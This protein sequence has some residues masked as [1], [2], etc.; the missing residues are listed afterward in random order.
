MAFHAPAVL[1]VAAP[2]DIPTQEL[3]FQST[4]AL[5]ALFRRACCNHPAVPNPAQPNFLQ[6]I[7]A[8]L[9]ANQRTQ[10]FKGWIN[11]ETQTGN[12]YYGEIHDNLVTAIPDQAHRDT[13]LA[14][15]NGVR[16]VVIGIENH[17]HTHF[18]RWSFDLQVRRATTAQGIQGVNEPYHYDHW[19]GWTQFGAGVN[20]P[21]YVI[22]IYWQNYF[23]V[24]RTLQVGHLGQLGG[25][26]MGDVQ[27]LGPG[28]WPFKVAI[29][30]QLHF[31]HRPGVPNPQYGAQTMAANPGENWRV[32]L[33]IHADTHGIPRRLHGGTISTRATRSKSRSK[34]MN[35][36][37]QSSKR[38][39]STRSASKPSPSKKST[40]S[41][42]LSVIIYTEVLKLEVVENKKV[43]RFKEED[44][45]YLTKEN[46]DD[47]KV[48]KFY[49]KNKHWLV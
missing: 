39:E 4:P 34:T 22:C 6:F 17:L 28:D 7:D 30:D 11:N 8:M 14:F 18:N 21:R 15:C 26:H 49:P 43:Y 37:K 13:C 3:T 27:Y 35:S 10:P 29:V 48:K 41:K 20:N 31:H 12:A 32:M 24:S 44:I 2:P 36:I 1:P 23:P 46:K 5:D 45:L 9:P 19:G 33:R 42:T 16:D 38:S 40:R 47:P 25:V